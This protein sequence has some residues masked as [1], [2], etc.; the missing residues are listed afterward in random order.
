M[1]RQLHPSV[2]SKAALGAGG[3]LPGSSCSQSV[4]RKSSPGS[5]HPRWMSGVKAYGGHRARKWQQNQ[6]GL[7]GAAAA[8]AAEGLLPVAAGEGGLPLVTKAEA[9]CALVSNKEPLGCSSEWV[10]MKLPCSYRL[11][12][13]SPLSLLL[14]SFLS[15]IY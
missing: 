15:V 14:L 1:L 12:D 9:T 6:R 4:Q 3:R 7:H 13:I 11:R 2:T 10:L 5:S 8:S